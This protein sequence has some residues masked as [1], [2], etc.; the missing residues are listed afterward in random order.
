M[1]EIQSSN[2]AVVTGISDPNKSR[3]R[4]RHT[5]KPGSKLKYLNLKQYVQVFEPSN[6]RSEKKRVNK[7]LFLS[8]KTY[9]SINLS[10]I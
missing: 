2:P 6:I 10:K 1:Q 3:E 4:H 5:L 7:N 9:F 8:C